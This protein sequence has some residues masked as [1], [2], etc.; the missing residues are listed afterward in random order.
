MVKNAYILPRGCESQTT[1]CIHIT[2][3]GIR[4]YSFL[5]AVT[6]PVCCEVFFLIQYNTPNLWCITN[7]TRI[8]D[9][10][11]R[12]KK[13]QYFRFSRRNFRS[14][15]TRP[16]SVYDSQYRTSAPLTQYYTYTRAHIY[17][18]TPSSCSVAI[19]AVYI[20]IHTYECRPWTPHEIIDELMASGKYVLY[21]WNKK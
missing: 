15:E 21:E 11:H 14:D 16:S 19:I 8:P 20:Y 3:I 13:M 6:F 12:E 5:H 4:I 17:I 7:L 1:L 18:Y 9:D 2:H 10:V